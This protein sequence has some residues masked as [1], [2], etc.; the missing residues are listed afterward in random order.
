MVSELQQDDPKNLYDRL[1]QI[2]TPIFVAFGDKEPFIP[3]TAFNGLTDLGRDIITPFMTRMTNA[4]NRPILK[5]YPDTG[6]FIHTDNP[7]EICCRRRGLRDQGNGRQHQLAACD[8]SHDPRGY[9]IGA[10]G[11]ADAGRRVAHGR[12]E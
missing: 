11:G 12:P 4:G 1:T 3:G 7:V 9:C 6:H 5:I 10:P 8:R 2:K